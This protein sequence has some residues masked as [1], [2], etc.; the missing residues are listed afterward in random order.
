MNE[1][2]IDTGAGVRHDP[3][4]PDPKD[5]VQEFISRH[6]SISGDVVRGGGGLCLVGRSP[7]SL[8]AKGFVVIGDAASQTIPMTGCGAGGAMVG[9]KYAAEAV[10]AAAQNG[11]TSCLVGIQLKVVCRIEKGRS[12][13]RTKRI[14]KYPAGS[15]P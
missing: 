6:P 2:E 14:K 11:K 15:D 9:G 13:R 3:K 7:A 1:D 5:I 4:N 10:L 12:L 8:V